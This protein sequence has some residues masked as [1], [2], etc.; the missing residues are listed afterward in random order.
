MR[1]T[2]GTYSCRCCKKSGSAWWDLFGDTGHLA[3]KRHVDSR[4]FVESTSA[5]QE[6]ED[7]EAWNKEFQSLCNAHQETLRKN[8]AAFEEARKVVAKIE[9][10][11]TAQ[12]DSPTVMMMVMIIK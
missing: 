7:R 4:S 8:A 10:L 2:K 3:S 12:T 6:S 1:I 11:A 5:S 9:T